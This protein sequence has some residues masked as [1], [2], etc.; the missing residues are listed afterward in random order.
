MSYKGINWKKFSK[1]NEKLE[2][3][4]NRGFG[5]DSGFGSDKKY[6]GSDGSF[7]SG[8][9]FGSDSSFESDKKNGKRLGLRSDDSFESGSRFGSDSS[10]G[11]NRK[12]RGWFGLGS[13]SNFGS[14]ECYNRR[15]NGKYRGFL[16]GC[17][18]EGFGS[19][20]IEDICVFKKGLLEWDWGNFIYDN[21]VGGFYFYKESKS[22]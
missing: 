13:D 20:S 6:G 17:F 14:G 8:S 3:G 19:G 10:F 5:S 4:L 12:Y 7:E 9:R 2:I 18:F 1:G 15:N 22:F 16:L 11:S 21:K